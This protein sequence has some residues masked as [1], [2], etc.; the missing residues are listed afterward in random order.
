MIVGIAY[1][2][3]QKPQA[4]SLLLL[5]EKTQKLD[6]NRVNLMWQLADATAN[7][8]PIKALPIASKALHLARSIDYKDGQSRATGVVANTFIN[9]GNYPRALE[10]YFRMLKLEE[11]GSNYRNM[12]SVLMNIGVVHVYQEEYQ[13]ALH[14]YR[15][16]DSVIRVH[17]IQSLLFYSEQNLGDIY[18]RLNKIDSSFTYFKAA[19]ERAKQ[20]DNPTFIAAS[21]TGLGHCY[22]KM[23]D[24]VQASLH[25]HQALSILQS[26]NHDE[27]YCEALLGLARLH[28]DNQSIDSASL[29][30]RLSMSVAGRG[31]FISRQL[32]AAQFLTDHFSAATNK[33]SAYAYLKE[34]QALNESIN[35]KDRIRE[36][37]V[38]LSNEQ[39]RQAELEEERI[40]K[41]NERNQQ[42]QLLFIGMFIPGF[43]LLTLLLS[44]IR[45]PQRVIKVMGI[46]SLLFLFEFLTLLLHPRVADLTHHTP[47]LEL[48]IFVG[49]AAILIPMHHKVEH[50][51]VKKLI[52]RK[53]PVVEENISEESILEE[54]ISEENTSEGS[55]S[56]KEELKKPPV[57]K[58]ALENY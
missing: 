49:I 30:G 43:F 57:D 55:R 44:R 40:A 8:D 42:L 6:S 54:S 37:Q 14:Y 56:E 51:F 34:V 50:W 7:Y 31:G 20:Q 5:L 10:Y 21:L 28:H 41:A 18:E 15:R 13:Q 2:F 29:Y 16:S 22:R 24:R 38:L 58:E 45:V 46:L 39:V 17:N 19:H 23:Q 52:T 25:Y 27:L 35:S 48:L 32:D 1:T 11:N 33:D 47:V 3:A 9:I 12:A 36:L 26:I 4:D 53:V